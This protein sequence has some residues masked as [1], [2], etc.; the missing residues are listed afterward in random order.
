MGGM[1][2]MRRP[3]RGDLI[4]RRFCTAEVFGAPDA[5]RWGFVTELMGVEDT[6]VAESLVFLVLPPRAGVRPQPSEERSS[7]APQLA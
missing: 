2:L 4:R 1:V 6:H 3:A 7:R 5:V